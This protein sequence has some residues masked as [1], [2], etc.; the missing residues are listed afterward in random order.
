M[1]I[2]F[3]PYLFVN[4]VG[5]YMSLEIGFA[6]LELVW[7]TVINL[8]S[9]L[10]VFFYAFEIKLWPP[11]FWQVCFILFIADMV[12]N[13]LFPS[14]VFAVTSPLLYTL[15][16]LFGMGLGLPAMISVYLYAFKNQSS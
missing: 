8:F 9:L 3:W 10:A 4:L 14:S 16:Y 11:I 7:S 6:D 1:K 2:Y 13:L 5:A 15:C 12:Y